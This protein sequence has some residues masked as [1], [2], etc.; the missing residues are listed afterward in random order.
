VLFFAEF[1]NTL[2]RKGEPRILLRSIQRYAAIVAAVLLLSHLA[3]ASSLEQGIALY[4]RENN[5]EAA[6][7]LKKAREE[8]PASSRAAYYLG[9]TYKRLQ[10]YKE[11][12]KHLTDAVTLEPK[13]KEAL[14]ELIETEYQLGDTDEALR[15]IAVAEKQEVRPAQVAFLKG[16]VLL[17]ADRPADA[18]ESFTAAKELDGALRQTADYQIGMAHM[19]Q[20]SFEEAAQAFREVMLLDPNTDIG[21]YAREYAEALERREGAQR[22]WKLNLGFFGE[23]DD[24]VV[25]RPSDASAV[26]DVGDEDDFREVVTTSAEWAHRFTERFAAKLNYDLYF[27]NQE[28]LSRFD[29]N[30]HTFGTTPT[31]FSERW[32]LSAPVTYNYTWVAND[33]FL[34]TVSAGPVLNLRA[35]DAQLYQV[36]V[37]VQDKNF[38]ASPVS[39]EEDRDAFRWAP[40]LQWFWFFKENQG[41]FGARYEYDSEDADGVNWDY[42]GH[43]VN[44]SFQWPFS[45]KLKGT[46][47]AEY[48]AQDF[49]NTHTT[50][51]M[52]RDDNQ[53]TLSA[54]LSYSFTKQ[55]EVQCRYTYVDHSSNISIYDYDR[56]VY[57]TGVLY[58]F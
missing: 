16:L 52:R 3:H 37:R 53:L 42:D 34:S 27:A 8:D 13:I 43:R 33:S 12:S 28:D 49:D 29:V 23:F 25:L 24:N 19:K 47:A 41:F 46:L 51:G 9:L 44:L 39:P 17:K 15:W 20:K 55:L 32:T 14:I 58:R 36:S 18:I 6:E 11:A 45:A 40:A 57:S 10:R 2:Y 48:Y 54:L 21:A 31:W 30:S 38:R 7:V 35:G 4:Q 56:N 1:L 26:S 50:F 5:D 22:P